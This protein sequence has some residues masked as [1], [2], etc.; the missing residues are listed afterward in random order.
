MQDNEDKLVDFIEDKDVLGQSKTNPSSTD[1]PP[2]TIQTIDLKESELANNWD[3]FLAGIMDMLIIG[4]LLY[5]INDCLL[6]PDLSLDEMKNSRTILFSNIIIACLYHGFLDSSNWQGTVEKKIMGIKIIHESGDKISFLR[7]IGRYL[8]SSISGLVILL[9]YVSILRDK[10]RQAWHDMMVSTYVIK[11][12][13]EDSENEKIFSDKRMLAYVLIIVLLIGQVYIYRKMYN[14][15]LDSALQE[16]KVKKEQANLKMAEEIV[17]SSVVSKGDFIYKDTVNKFQII[18]KDSFSYA[19]TNPTVQ[20]IAISN[21]SSALSVYYA[22]QKIISTRKIPPGQFLNEMQKAK[23]QY[24][25]SDIKL[26]NYKNGYKLEEGKMVIDKDNELKYGI[27]KDYSKGQT[28][29]LVFIIYD[30]EEQFKQCANLTKEI[31][32]SFDILE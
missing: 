22:T 5:L 18:V 25:F 2:P 30:S 10:N 20:F 31:F 16:I 6:F 12:K 29:Y 24:H 1:S 26:S 15:F 27:M 19:T 4:I 9:G 8:G 13:Q 14:R 32:D 7:A 17:K 11:G 21:D 3:R 23:P 28:S